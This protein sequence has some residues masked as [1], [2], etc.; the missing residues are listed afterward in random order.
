MKNEPQ[1]TRIQM[2]AEGLSVFWLA[3]WTEGGDSIEHIA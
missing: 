2:N 1:R 3:K